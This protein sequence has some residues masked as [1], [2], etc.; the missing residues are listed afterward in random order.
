MKGAGE[1][2]LYLDFDGVMHHENVLWHP[3]IGAYLSTPDDGDLLFEHAELLEQLLEPYPHIRIVLS[4]SWVI[5]YGCARATNNLRPALRSRV[6]G[7]TYPIRTDKRKFWETPRGLQVWSDVVRRKP[8]SWLALDDDA[9]GWPDHALA[10]FVQTHPHQ[11]I[12]EPAVLQ[13]LKTKLE[14]LSRKEREE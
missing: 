13:E 5:R 2:V 11:G 1:T 9:A 12:S 14:L 3:R 7:A 4:T 6:I 10:H 8:R